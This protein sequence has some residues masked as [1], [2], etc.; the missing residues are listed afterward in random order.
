MLCFHVFRLVDVKEL[1][2][3]S[4]YVFYTFGRDLPEYRQLADFELPVMTRIHV[5][6]GQLL[7][8]FATEKRVFVPLT[9]VPPRVIKA[10][11]AAED[12]NFYRHMGLDP[13]GIL[14]AVLT[15]IKY[16]GKSRRKVGASTITQQVAKLL[17]MMNKEKSESSCRRQSL[18]RKILEIPFSI[19]LELKFS[20][21]E[22]LSI[23]M[24][25]VYLGAN[26]V[27]FEAAAQRYFDKSATQV[28]VSESAMLA[29]LLKAPSRYAPTRDLILAQNR[30][31]IV[32]EAML[33]ENFISSDDAKAA[34][35][36]PA[37]LSKNA[38]SLL[39]AHFVDWI[40][41]DAPTLLTTKTTEDILIKTTFDPIVQKK[42]ESSISKIFKSYVRQN[43]KADV[44]VVVMTSVGDV[45]S[46]LG[47]RNNT[48]MAG[49]YNRAF[50]AYRQ[51][52]SVFKI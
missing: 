17:C 37:T 25:R 48:S 18:A 47:G 31:R 35:R 27:G 51:P 34:I 21:S 13:L 29:G 50:Q 11:L 24:N 19:A 38:Q 3:V 28:S 12:K 44:A 42:V 46:M 2:C 45:V 36:S 20:K 52:G 6:D 41:R 10:F 16:Y 23:Y 15:N 32:I 22:I 1:C 40:M 7:A 43:S 39:G 14:R 5:G 26:T 33:R 4:F 8:E 30:A 49:Q 9:A